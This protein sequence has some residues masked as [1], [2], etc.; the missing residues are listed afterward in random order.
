M[1]YAE[2]VLPELEERTQALKEV[3]TFDPLLSPLV[4]SSPIDLKDCEYIY[5][6][7]CLYCQ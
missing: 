1:R 4:Y 6:V 3:Q 7:N 2:W 5:K